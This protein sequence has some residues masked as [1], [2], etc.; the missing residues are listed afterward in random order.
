MLDAVSS[1][2]ALAEGFEEHDCSGG[3][4]VEGAD[5]ASHRNAQQMV[6]GAADEVVEASALAAENE[7]A[8]AGEIE[9]V[10]VG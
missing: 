3:G 8:V 2:A 9:L 4:D 7:D 5:A 6:A 10:V 1:V